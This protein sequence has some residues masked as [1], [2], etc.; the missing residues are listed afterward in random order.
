MQ[1]VRFLDLHE[2]QSKALMTKFGVR[3]QIGDV[4]DT[5]AGALTVAKKLK[6]TLCLIVVCVFLYVCMSV[7]LSVCMYVCMKVRMYVCMCW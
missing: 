5:P 2:Y 1:Q 3:V 7:C 6:G 4:A